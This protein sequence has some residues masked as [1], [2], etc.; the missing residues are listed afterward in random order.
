MDT[1]GPVAGS[2]SG[3]GGWGGVGAENP[4]SE[5]RVDTEM[6]LAIGLGPRPL[7]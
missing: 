2:P 4:S 3:G 5:V 6:Q 1:N 7:L